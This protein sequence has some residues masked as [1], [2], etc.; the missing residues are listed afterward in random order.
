MV[1]LTQYDTYRRDIGGFAVRRAGRRARGGWDMTKSTTTIIAAL[2][3]VGLSAGAAQAATLTQMLGTVVEVGGSPVTDGQTF[4]SGA[5]TGSS[6]PAPVDVA[7]GAD[8]R[9]PT[10]VGVGR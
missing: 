10:L 6:D 2:V 3:A 9:R 4:A 7:T 5:F 8:G 1:A